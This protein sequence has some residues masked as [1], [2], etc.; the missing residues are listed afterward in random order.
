MPTPPVWV[1]SPDKKLLDT[2]DNYTP[3][4]EFFNKLRKILDDNPK[5]DELRDEEQEVVD[6]ASENTGDF[7]AQYK[8]GRLFEELGKY[9]KARKFYNRITGE[10]QTSANGAGA[11][12]ALARMARY[13]KDW[14]T[15]KKHLEKCRTANKNNKYDLADNIAMEKAYRL[16]D[17]EK[18]EEARSLLVDT[19]QNHPDSERMGELQFYAGVANFFL[20]N[21]KWANYHWVW[22][23]ENIPRDFNYMKC[24]LTATVEAMPWGNP[25]LDGY[26]GDTDRV[27]RK[28]VNRALKK[29]KQDYRDMKEKWPPETGTDTK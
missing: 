24:Y 4:R 11:E 1:I 6:K 8:A 15:A 3:K 22:V 17:E 16:L 21:R 28:M 18:H 19:I 5:Y 27:N 7:T 2:I 29:S 12:L 20:D 26:E 10:D 25:E 14:D 9:K 13:E 23:M